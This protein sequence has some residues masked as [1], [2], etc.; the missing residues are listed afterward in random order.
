VRDPQG[1]VMRHIARAG[2]GKVCTSIIVACELRFGAAKKASPRLTEQLE[3]VLAAL[4]VLALDTDADHRYRTL[5]TDLE[6][7]GTPIGANDMLIAAHALSLGLTL[8]TNNVDEFKRVK[9]LTLRN[10]LAS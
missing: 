9:G 7:A 6:R 2:E 10:W 8:I 5:R 4:P 3:Q 1:L